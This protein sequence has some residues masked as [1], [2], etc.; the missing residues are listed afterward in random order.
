MS[1]KQRFQEI[2]NEIRGDLK[3]LKTDLFTQL[4]KLVMQKGYIVDADLRDWIY[5][6]FL[7]KLFEIDVKIKKIIS[8]LVP[9][10][11]ADL[12][13]IKVKAIAERIACGSY[14]V[15]L[16]LKDDLSKLCD[17]L[18]NYAN[19]LE[20]IMSTI[21]YILQENSWVQVKKLKSEDYVL[22]KTR[23]KYVQARDELK[24]AKQA[25]KDGKYEDVLNHLRPAIELAIKER[26]G[27]TRITMKT[28]LLDAEKFDFPLPSYTMLYDYYNEGSQRI[29]G[30]KLNTPF[31]CQEAL[32]FVARFIDRLDL[33]NVSQKDINAFKTKSKAVE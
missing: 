12:P 26:F 17:S 6:T 32:V 30:G 31:E 22:P 19:R 21:R 18:E 9:R 8:D 4:L 13:W 15:D 7:D 28:F 27:F 1:E 14:T 24:K 29:H 2:L 10:F 20:S 25:V 23:A 11:E 33:I 3:F 5:D 16:E